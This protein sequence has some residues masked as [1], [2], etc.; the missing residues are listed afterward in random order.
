MPFKTE[1]EMKK[2]IVE[3]IAR[4]DMSVSEISRE[5][6][7]SRK[8]AYKWKARY[9]EQGEV[10]LE[11]RS[12][13]PQRIKNEVSEEV[14]CKIVLIR[15]AHPTWGPDKIRAVLKREKCE[16]LPSK[17]SIYRVLYKSGL[18][19]KRRRMRVKE[20]CRIASAYQAQAS[21][22]V[23]TVDFKGDWY[24]KEGVHCRPLTL[25]DE[26]SRFLLLVE[27]MDDGKTETVK[28][29]FKKV[30]IKYGLPRAIRSDNG[31]P[32]ASSKAL[33]GLSKLSAWWIKLGIKLIRSRPGK[34]QDNGGHERMHADLAR[35]IQYPKLS[36]QF[37]LDQ[38]KRGF[39]YERPHAALNDDTPSQHYTKST[40]KYQCDEIE[41][42]YQECLEIRKVDSRGGTIN[43]KKKRLFLSTSLGEQSVGIY[44]ETDTLLRV[45]YAGYTLGYIDE[46]IESFIPL[47]TLAGQLTHDTSSSTPLSS[48]RSESFVPSEVL[49]PQAPNQS[50]NNLDFINQC[51]TLSSTK[52]SPTA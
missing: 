49:P 18:V 33:L 44:V 4:G 19:K 32:F 5:Y 12:R 46:E 20:G 14:L 25:R 23:W 11:N 43:W 50:H 15:N 24:S 22:D 39:N 40:R 31:S 38:W 51:V 48:L 3:A 16:A 29:A 47:E 13:R 8:T 28:E 27:F 26:H 34:P 42:D 7:V 52:V 2:E 21:N 35:E 37:H 17:S 9:E 30:F 6:K 1:I 41:I 45:Q 36:S 10:G